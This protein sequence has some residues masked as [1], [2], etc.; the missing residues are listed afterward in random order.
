MSLN[1]I[2]PC[3]SIIQVIASCKPEWLVKIIGPNK[4]IIKYGCF[5][6]ECD[7]SMYVEWLMND[8]C[9]CMEAFPYVCCVINMIFVLFLS[10]IKK[11]R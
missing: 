5:Q 8:D 3:L 4:R 11:E 1:L 2:F 6:F 10:F 7:P 9:F